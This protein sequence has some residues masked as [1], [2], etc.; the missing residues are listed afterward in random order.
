MTVK[1]TA[2]KRTGTDNVRWTSAY[3][4]APLLLVATTLAPVVTAEQSQC[5]SA[6]LAQLCTPPFDPEDPLADSQGQQ[7]DS[8]GIAD[9]DGQGLACTAVAVLWANGC[10]SATITASGELSGNSV[11]FG[12]FEIHA[13]TEAEVVACISLAASFSVG[14]LSVLPGKNYV[15]TGTYHGVWDEGTLKQH[16]DYMNWNNQQCTNAINGQ[17]SC[18]AGA[19]VSMSEAGKCMVAYAYSSANNAPTGAS[20]VNEVAV[21]LGAHAVGSAM[22]RLLIKSP[23]C[24]RAPAAPDANPSIPQYGIRNLSPHDRDE[25]VD[26]IWSAMTPAVE[27]AFRPWVQTNNPVLNQA[28]QNF[29][30]SLH[31]SLCEHL[32]AC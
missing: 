7:S 5:T 19:T 20:E 14:A 32:G 26:A 10:A 29:T 24:K 11:L 21:G 25:I 13:E 8:K 9:C 30:Q 15:N 23:E 16:Q 12:A 27:G 18:Q 28:A 2:K 17:K 6:G 3:S 31:N 1:R 22:S 4:L